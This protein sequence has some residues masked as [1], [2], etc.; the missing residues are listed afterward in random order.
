M[1]SLWTC[2]LVFSLRLLLTV[3]VETDYQPGPEE[4]DAL[5]YKDPC[6]AGNT[7]RNTIV[8]HL[9]QCICKSGLIQCLMLCYSLTVC[10]VKGVAMLIACLFVLCDGGAVLFALCCGV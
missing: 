7:A 10:F 9:Y 2:S 5:D 4:S 6:K 3:E 1:R 8:T